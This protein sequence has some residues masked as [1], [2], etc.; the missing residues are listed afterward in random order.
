M[1]HLDRLNGAGILFA[2]LFVLS[3]PNDGASIM[4]VKHQPASGNSAIHLGKMPRI[5][6]HEVST[7]Q[8]TS[9][10]AQEK[11]KPDLD[12]IPQKVMGA[13]KSKFPKAEIHKWTKEKEGDVVV[14][15]FEFKQDGQKFEADIKEDGAIHNW[16]K[17]IAAKDLPDAVKKA[18]ETRYP[19]PIMKEVMAITAVKDGKEALEGYEIVL[20]VA[21]KKE[22]EVT[23]ASDG[24]M[25]EDSGEKK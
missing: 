11:D 14:Y 10:T 1:K 22:V 24:K 21:D 9:F 2:A 25:L 23:V 7:K 19:K 17:A 3:F 15:D 16:E 18:V 6:A 8:V 12:K 4:H 5:A 20:E 13:L